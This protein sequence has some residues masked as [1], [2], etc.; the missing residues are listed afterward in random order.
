MSKQ[1]V[2]QGLPKSNLQ[3]TITYSPEPSWLEQQLKEG[4][5]PLQF[6]LQYEVGSDYVL[7]S[8]VVCKKNFSH[9]KINPSLASSAYLLAIS[10]RLACVSTIAIGISEQKQ[11]AHISAKAIGISWQM[12]LCNLQSNLHSRSITPP[13]NALSLH[14]DNGDEQDHFPLALLHKT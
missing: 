6:I 13:S 11:L 7:S 5:Q 4:N 10:L 2:S 14:T 9:Y 12:T 1:L 3:A 8:C